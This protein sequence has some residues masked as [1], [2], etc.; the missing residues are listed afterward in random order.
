MNMIIQLGVKNVRLHGVLTEEAL[1][2]IISDNLHLM[3]CEFGDY[4]SFTR[5]VTFTDEEIV[6]E[7]R[8]G[9]KIIKA[10]DSV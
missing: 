2:E 5:E 9:L 6:T 10:I 4:D 3:I 8:H 1:S 7:N